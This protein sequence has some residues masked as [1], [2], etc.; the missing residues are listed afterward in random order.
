VAAEFSD[1]PPA[2]AGPPPD[3]LLETVIQRA[4]QQATRFGGHRSEVGSEH[5]L[6]SL[7]ATIPRLAEF[8]AQHALPLDEL[9]RH[10]GEP[11]AA[12]E[13]LPAEISIVWK[14]GDET[15]HHDVLRIVDAAANRIR[16]GL[17]VLEDFV[18]FALDDKHLTERLKIWRHDFARILTLIE[19]S[20]LLSARETQ[21]DVGTRISTLSES[22]RGSLGEVVQAN[23]KRMQ[24]ALRTL[25]EYGKILSPL[26]G[27]EVERLRYEVYILEK[28]VLQTQAA[29]QRL[30]GRPLYLLVTEGLC[31]HGAGPAIREALAGG[32]GIVQIREKSMPDRRLVAHGRRVREWT[33]DADALLIMN[34]RPDLAVLI[35]AD[36]V[37]VG[38]DELSV[39]DARRIVGPGKLVGVS[40]HTLE[41]VRQAVLDGADYIGVGPI[42]PS[43]TKAFSEFA[44]L[45]FVKQVAA[46]ITLPAFAIGGITLAN[47]EQ[48][49]AAGLSRVAV[50]S[51]LCSVEHP[52]Q[53]AQE[54][55]SR[56]AGSQPEAP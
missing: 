42:F 32:V 50:S 46:E 33:R 16:E 48:V 27:E 41:Q 20:D 53:A 55:L 56:L 7:A 12:H 24:E 36:G 2:P 11:V 13:P 44:G 29:R 1:S 15:E 4:R 34:D 38:Q 45:D 17:R 14:E 5:L 43:T 23:F 37:H 51:A 49:I 39:R 6:W 19:P 25:E 21:H 31:H 52:R 26:L 22:H 30:A 28:A 54:F 47:L 8:L 3:E 9:A 40:T 10:A 35:E 18:R